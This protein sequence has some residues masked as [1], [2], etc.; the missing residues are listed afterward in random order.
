MTT[1]TSRWLPSYNGE[2]TSK[3]HADTFR[4]LDTTENPEAAF[5]V[6]TYLLD[7]AS[8][9]LLDV[10]GGMPA[11]TEARDPFFAA[12]DETFTQGVNWQVAIDS[13]AY[14]D[15]P[16]HEG[17]MPNFDEAEARIDEFETLI[18]SDPNADMA[19]E[20]A[21]LQADLTTIFAAGS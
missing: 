8:A 4:I 18:D 20:A 6:L 14:P 10:Y 21:R 13:L 5:E 17:N 9:D 7:D 19:A 3:L 2:T 16:S 1:S 11:R 15:V 12:L